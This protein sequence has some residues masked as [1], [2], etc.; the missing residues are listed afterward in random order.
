MKIC[1]DSAPFRPI[2]IT[3]DTRE[4]ADAFWG[5]IEGQKDE[6]GTIKKLSVRLSNWF[7]INYKLCPTSTERETK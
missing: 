4:E 5:L 7:T 2:R 3:L 1:Q 6:D